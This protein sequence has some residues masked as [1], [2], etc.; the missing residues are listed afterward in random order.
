MAKSS[1]TKDS[2][3]KDT[4]TAAANQPQPLTTAVVVAASETVHRLIDS[5][6]DDVNMP[7]AAY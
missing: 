7:T 2:S 1:Y 4:I 6:E 5:Q 3:D